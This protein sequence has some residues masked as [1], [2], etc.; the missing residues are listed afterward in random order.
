MP[1]THNAE[2]GAVRPPSR[3]WKKYLSHIP[4]GAFGVS[5]SVDHSPPQLIFFR[6]LS[7]AARSCY[8]ITLNEI[9]WS[10]RAI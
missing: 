3:P 7:T 2:S 10:R 8:R 1:K 4:V 6:K 5:I 9:H